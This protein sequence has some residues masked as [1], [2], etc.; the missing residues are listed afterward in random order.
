MPG[1]P[2][3][4]TTLWNA[5][6]MIALAKEPKDLLP[7]KEA[8]EW[9]SKRASPTGILAEQYNPLTGAPLSV[10]PLIWSHSTYVDTV[11]RFL[12]K[13]RELKA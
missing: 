11:L 13:E 1:N 6:W 7:A 4:I 9:V 2:W 5:Q 10:A 3:I 8:L 12:E